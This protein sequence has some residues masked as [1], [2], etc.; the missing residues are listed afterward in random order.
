MRKPRVYSEVYN[1]LDGEVACL[2]RM[3]R[4]PDTA[5]KL[6]EALRLTPFA[7]EE[8]DGAYRDT[9]DAIELSRR[10]IVRS[11]MGFG[12][13]ACNKNMST[14]FRSNSNR[15]GTTPAHDW[16]H[17][18]DCLDAMTERLRGVVI[19]NRPAL[20]IFGQHDGPETLHYVDPPYVHDTRKPGQQKN[21]KFEMTDE[22]H[23]ELAAVLRGLQGS[24]VLSG[25]PSPLYD[26][27]YAGW[28]RYERNALADGAEKRVEVLWL[29]K[30]AAESNRELF[31][32]A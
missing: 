9:S 15:S 26:E 11:F 32:V 12:S 8:F 30:K 7:R 21:Y 17:Y 13:N 5:A 27:L 3:L 23:R 1:D 6:K 19:E 25:Y 20:E 24:I 18:P 16:A 14:G 29:N 10:L 28:D 2:F 4:D 31:P 22:A